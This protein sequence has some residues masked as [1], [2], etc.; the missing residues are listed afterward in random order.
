MGQG[1][2][3][4]PSR[5]LSPYGAGT[6]AGRCRGANLPA[7]TTAQSQGIRTNCGES[8]T[9]CVSGGDLRGGTHVTLSMANELP[10]RLR[11]P[12]AARPMLYRLRV[13]G[14]RH[15]LLAQ[16]LGARRVP[17]AIGPGLVGARGELLG[18]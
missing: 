18:E 12:Q 17:H 5:S 7:I 10:A 13:H 4:P 3:S 6:L 16:Q 11:A 8:R 1:S 2:S 9:K 15:R 14:L